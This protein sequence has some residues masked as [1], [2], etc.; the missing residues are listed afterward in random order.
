MRPALLQ[1]DAD[2]VQTDMAGV[3]GKLHWLLE[4]NGLSRHLAHLPPLDA[5]DG[6]D[7]VKLQRRAGNDDD[8]SGSGEGDTSTPTASP[9]PS[10]T[11]SDPRVAYAISY[12]LSSVVKFDKMTPAD[13][14]ATKKAVRQAFLAATTD[15]EESDILYIRLYES[16]S[17]R[18]A[19][20]DLLADVVL[21]GTVTAAEATAANVALGEVTI[22]HNGGEKKKEAVGAGVLVAAGTPVVQDTD[23]DGL[24]GGAVAGIII[25]VLIIVGAALF[26]VMKAQ[27]DQRTDTGSAWDPASMPLETLKMAEHES[28]LDLRISH[29]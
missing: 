14:T 26:V 27:K 9:T 4:E 5:S 7:L 29:V 28:R 25:L 23:D 17:R 11:T 6:Y 1:G 21:K 19:A 20:G 8:E 16:E 10:P 15:V 3:D 13:R 12:V 2:V 24:G 22:N 18:R